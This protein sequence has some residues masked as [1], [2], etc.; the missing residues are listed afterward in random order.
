LQG[1]QKLF[2]TFIASIISWLQKV[3]V[4]DEEA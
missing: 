2:H 1:K 4:G 3:R